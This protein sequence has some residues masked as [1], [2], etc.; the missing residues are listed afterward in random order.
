VPAACAQVSALLWRL[1]RER[2]DLAGQLGAARDYFLLAR[3]DFY[4]Q[5]LDEVGAALLD[6]PKK[7]WL[8]L[9]GAGMPCPATRV[10]EAVS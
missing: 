1:V 9:A 3:G 8:G 2:C 7:L 4:Q 6:L 5:F 10:A